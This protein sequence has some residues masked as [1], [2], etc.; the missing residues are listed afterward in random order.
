[1]KE[2]Q[3]L[4]DEII[5]WQ[6]K[7]FPTSDAVSKLHHLS[8]EVPELIEAILEE[9]SDGP[10]DEQVKNTEME[11]ADNFLLLFGSAAIYGL[12][13]KGIERVVREKLEINKKRKWG[14]PDAQGVVSHVKE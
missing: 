3:V 10:T 9:D 7:T 6:V 12:D 2:L 11:Y 4:I 14:Q 13:A 5:E 8:R 1:M